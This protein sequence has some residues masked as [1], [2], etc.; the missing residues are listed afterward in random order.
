MARIITKELA[1][2]NANK[3]LARKISKKNRPHDDYVVIFDG[4][5][6]TR[7]GI[8]RSSKKD[9]GHD[10]IPG[11]IHLSPHEAKLFAQCDITYE[12]WVEKM[13]DLGLIPREPDQA[14]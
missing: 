6:I 9:M 8:R 10:H 3:L 1:T 14:N 7:F 13:R 5:L 2:A 4:R 12:A 11:A